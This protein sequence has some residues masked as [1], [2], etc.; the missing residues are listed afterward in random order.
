MKR[1][2]V[3]SLVG[4]SSFLGFLSASVHGQSMYR[5]V[6]GTNMKDYSTPGY[7]IQ[8]MQNGTSNLYQTIPG[9]NIRDYSQPGLRLEQDN[10]G[11][12]TAYPTV[13][14]TNIRD[15]SQPGWKMEP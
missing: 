4:L 13:P 12:T 6:P 10:R 8:P 1:Y 3:V 9:T 14:G 7:R 15:Y 11:G 5:T 2:V